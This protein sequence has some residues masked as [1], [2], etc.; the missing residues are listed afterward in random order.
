[1]NDD[2]YTLTEMLAA[3]AILGLAMGGLGLV[4][5]LMAR[6]QL[7]A[8]R[9]HMRLVDD[10]AADRA[11]THWLAGL[12]AETLNGDGRSLSA[13]CGLATC[14]AR[15]EID[16]ARAVLI[17]KARSGPARRFRLRQ[18]DVRFA[19]ADRQGD[20]AAWPRT[21]GVDQGGSENVL[22]TV[23]LAASDVAVPSAVARVWVRE[24]RDCQFDAIIGACRVAT[25]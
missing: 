7:T 5:S 20:L 3:L 14:S 19:Y 23:R 6:Q 13:S 21:D 4:V 18:R 9:A 22:R 1:M 11:L 24:P 17:L 10:R 12:D 15:L 25:P 2:G 16:G 8:N